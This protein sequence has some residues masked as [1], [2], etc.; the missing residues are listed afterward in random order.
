MA[1]PSTKCTGCCGSIRICFPNR[2]SALPS[3]RTGIPR[4]SNSTRSSKRKGCPGSECSV[5]GRRVEHRLGQGNPRLLAQGQH[6]ALHIPKLF[7]IELPNQSIYALRQTLDPVE[8]GEDTEI[9][10]H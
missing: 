4:S 6:P 2:P 9:L 3:G 7:E 1:S 8:Q 5:L 10:V